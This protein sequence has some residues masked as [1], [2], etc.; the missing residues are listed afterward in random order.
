[1]AYRIAADVVARISPPP[2]PGVPPQYVLA[3]VLAERHRRELARLR[4]SGPRHR[5]HSGPTRRRIP[6]PAV[7]WR[8]PPSCPPRAARAAADGFDAA[9]LTAAAAP[10]SISAEPSSGATVRTW[11]HAVHGPRYAPFARCIRRDSA[12]GCTASSRLLSG[13][14]NAI[15]TTTRQPRAAPRRRAGSRY[16]AAGTAR[17][18]TTPTARREQRRP[19]EQRQE[20]LRWPAP[21]R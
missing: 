16:P 9:E 2:P 17:A 14:L 13:T 5:R 6:S 10:I 1:M 8:S 18:A 21:R 11:F 4:P 12:A 15:V 20:R 3:A 19:E 7:V